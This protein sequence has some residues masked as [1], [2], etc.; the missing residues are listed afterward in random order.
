[1]NLTEQEQQWL[2]RQRALQQRVFVGIDHHS[3]QL[4]VAMASGEL[5]GRATNSTQ[6]PK[7]SR[8]H[9]IPPR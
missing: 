8:S 7:S 1:M 4:T 6:W 2:D 5:R 9:S 3:R